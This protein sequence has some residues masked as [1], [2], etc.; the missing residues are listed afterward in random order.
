MAGWT[1]AHAEVV[2]RGYR[3]VAL[4][5]DEPRRTEALRRAEGW[6]F[7]VLCDQERAVVR[8]LGLYNP[9][10]KG[11]I[12]VPATFVLDGELR[13]RFASVDTVRHRAPAEQVLAFL[14]GECTDGNRA[15]MRPGAH[16]WLRAIA[17][18]ARF[19]LRSPR[20]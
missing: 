12:A 1:A 17:G 14:R 15:E 2:A 11:G 20:R 4:S 16:G 7:P 6:P 5:V 10:E 9:D 19:G 3:L 8:S 13:V 18:V